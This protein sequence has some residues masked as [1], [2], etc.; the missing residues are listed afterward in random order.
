MSIAIACGV[1]ICIGRQPYNSDARENKRI[2][3]I[4]PLQLHPS[5]DP[6]MLCALFAPSSLGVLHLHAHPSQSTISV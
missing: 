4:S 2:K 5:M 1:H 6:H 3:S